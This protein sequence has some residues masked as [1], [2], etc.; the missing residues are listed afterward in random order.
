M[1]RFRMRN[2]TPIAIDVG[3]TCVRGLQLRGG[4]AQQR[5]AAQPAAEEPAQIF[6]RAQRITRLV[7]DHAFP[8]RGM[9]PPGGSCC[10]ASLR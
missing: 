8:F 3:S 7:G 6:L 4:R 1:V 9:I 5:I 2:T 10:P